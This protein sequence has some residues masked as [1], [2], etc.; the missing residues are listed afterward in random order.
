MIKIFFH[1]VFVSLFTITF[2]L[3]CSLVLAN[4]NSEL[5]KKLALASLMFK[6]GQ[7]QS[8]IEL[9]T[10][11]QGN[12]SET[13]VKF[14]LMGIASSKMQDFSKA[15]K[16]FSLALKNGSNS[17]DLFYEYGQ[18]LYAANELKK[19]LKAFAKSV[20]VDFN[21]PTSLYY[22]GHISQILEQHNEA[23]KYY[24]ELTKIKGVNEDLLQVATFQM[25][26]SM[27]AIVAEDKHPG[28]AIQKYI[29]PLLEKAI[30]INQSSSLV[31]DIQKRITELK[32]QYNLDPN[33]MKN[34]R[35]LPEKK[36]SFRYSDKLKYDNNITQST[37]LPSKKA[38]QKDAFIVDTQLYAKYQFPLF[39]RIVLEPEARLNYNWYGDRQDSVVFKNDN[40][41]YTPALKNRIEHLLFNTLASFLFDFEYYYTA[42]DSDAKKSPVFSGKYTSYQIGEKFKFFS[43]GDTSIKFKIKN[44]LGATVDGNNNVTSFSMDQIFMRSNSTM[45]MFTFQYD[46]TKMEVDE[47][48]NTNSLL[49]RMDYIIP[50]YWNNY[51]LNLS[52]SLTLLDTLVQTTRGLEK[53]YNP[54][55]KLTKNVGDYFKYALS[56]DYTKNTSK[57]KTSYDYDKHVTAFELSFN[58]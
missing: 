55:I 15:N 21:R 36:F 30:T 13:G 40:Y 6:E 47:N 33:R 56:Y 4:E 41:S 14:Y 12:K 58:Y 42:R 5:S 11:V 9:L 17:K 54:S 37:D 7:Y 52:F 35:V 49:A 22:L 43:G 53:T 18:S 34:G 26:E 25:S 19:A 8:M 27:T 48:Q 39:Q 1:P 57:D 2:N 31:A 16:Y 50:D 10:P 3:H 29:L 24:L 20:E 28:P 32:I 45:V 44:Y 51:S 23:R 38:L 46:Q